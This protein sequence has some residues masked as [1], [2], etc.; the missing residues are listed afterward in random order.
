MDKWGK[1]DDT[2]AGSREK[3]NFTGSEH[4]PVGADRPF[5]NYSRREKE[6]KKCDASIVF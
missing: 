5:C 2:S 1:G 6:I 4:K 3:Q